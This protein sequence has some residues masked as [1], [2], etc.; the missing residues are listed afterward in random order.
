MRYVQAKN[1]L[2]LTVPPSAAAGPGENTRILFDRR[3]R[4]MNSPIAGRML[5][6]RSDDC[7]TGT[8]LVRNMRLASVGQV[9][10]SKAACP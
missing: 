7:P 6:L 1:R 3:G 2:Q 8:D 9:T 10:T 5:S 4:Q